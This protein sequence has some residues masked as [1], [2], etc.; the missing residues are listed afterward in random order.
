MLTSYTRDVPSTLVVDLGLAL[1]WW[2]LSFINP[3]LILPTLC[4]SYHYASSFILYLIYIIINE[5]TNEFY[6]NGDMN[7]YIMFMLVPNNSVLYLIFSKSLIFY[8]RYLIYLFTILAY[9]IGAYYDARQLAPLK[10]IYPSVITSGMIICFTITFACEYEVLLKM[11]YEYVRFD[12]LFGTIIAIQPCIAIINMY[13]IWQNHNHSNYIS[14][15]CHQSIKK[16]MCHPDRIVQA[17]LL[18]DMS[19]IIFAGS[20]ILIISY[21]SVGFLFGFL[22]A[23]DSTRDYLLYTIGVSIATQLI[24]KAFEILLNYCCFSSNLVNIINYTN[25]ISGASFAFRLNRMLY[26]CAFDALTLPIRVLDLRNTIQF[27]HFM[28]GMQKESHEMIVR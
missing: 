2:T 10:L 27:K 20:F 6:R 8:S 25:M 13:A 11:N 28:L 17:D 22:L 5:S 7:L 16:E 19:N 4:L 1:N 3:L 12:Y 24:R 14:L 26:N 23:Y 15:D 18:S 9:L 21:N